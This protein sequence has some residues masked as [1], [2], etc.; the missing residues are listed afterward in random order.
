M[1]SQDLIDEILNDLEECR[2]R[3]DEQSRRLEALERQ[4]TPLFTADEQLWLKSYVIN[5]PPTEPDITCGKP[6]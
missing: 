5:V 6:Q 2:R 4:A 3:L 1:V